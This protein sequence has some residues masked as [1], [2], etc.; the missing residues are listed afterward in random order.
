MKSGSMEQIYF[1]FHVANSENNRWQQRIS[2][3]SDFEIFRTI[4][5][6]IAIV[7]HRAWVLLKV[8]L[9]SKKELNITL[10]NMPCVCTIVRL[11]SEALGELNK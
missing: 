10:L 6:H 3:D 2:V 7:P 4:H 5:K 9:T 11:K 8:I 1:D